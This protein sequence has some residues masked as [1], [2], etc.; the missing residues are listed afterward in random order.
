MAQAPFLIHSS[1]LAIKE[2]TFYKI[3]TK[4]IFAL[5]TTG[6][7]SDMLLHVPVLIVKFTYVILLYEGDGIFLVRRTAEVHAQSASAI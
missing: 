6:F 2:T 3:I 4:S 7:V 5:I 1:M